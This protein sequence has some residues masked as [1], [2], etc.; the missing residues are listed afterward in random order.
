M[1]M[2]AQ[3]AAFLSLQTLHQPIIQAQY[4]LLRRAARSYPRLCWPTAGPSLLC[5]SAESFATPAASFETSPFF[6]AARSSRPL[7]TFLAKPANSTIVMGSLVSVVL[8]RPTATLCFSLPFQM[9]QLCRQGDLCNPGTE[10][11]LCA[12][13]C[14]LKH[15][16]RLRLF[17]SCPLIMPYKAIARYFQ[18]R[19][20]CCTPLIH[21][22]FAAK[23]TL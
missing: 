20:G 13:R 7:T 2:A 9:A 19:L 10:N 11:E 17:D 12:T 22:D 1:A 5:D 14:C 23:N 15:L 16:F 18:I 21:C 6:G 4:G 3:L 8:S